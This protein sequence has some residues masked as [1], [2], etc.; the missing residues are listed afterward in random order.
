MRYE[1]KRAL[2]DDIQRERAALADML[3]MIPEDLYGEAG[4]WG[5][6]W[7]ILDLV[8]HLAEW[9][10]MLL[11]WYRVGSTGRTPDLPA[12]GFNWRE[13]PALNRAIRE[14]HR[15]RPYREVWS[16]FSRSHD[17]ILRLVHELSEEEILEPGHFGWTGKNALVAYVGANTASHY[18]F[19]QKV[20]KRWLKTRPDLSS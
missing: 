2:I 8:A 16:E 12:P 17:E 11:G 20:L 7:N 10:T 14:K 4:V 1:T 6:D 18:R 15:H 19:A 5:E 3:G 13:T 9:H